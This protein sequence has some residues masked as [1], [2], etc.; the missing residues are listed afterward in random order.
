MV[1]QVTPRF[2]FTLVHPSFQCVWVFVWCV[3]PP[4]ASCGWLGSPRPPRLSLLVL[5]RLWALLIDL[6]SG[7]HV[8]LL[9]S[10]PLSFSCIVFGS[11]L[12]CVA[13]G[14]HVHGRAASLCVCVCVNGGEAVAYAMKVHQHAHA[15]HSRTGRVR[16]AFWGSATGH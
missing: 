11:R 16:S 12:V 6:P 5:P 4:V 9:L 1:G 2:C 7:S 10:L 15:H 13:V 14:W 8:W 3:F